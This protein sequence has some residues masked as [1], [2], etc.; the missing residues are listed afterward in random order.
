ML[1]LFFP[2]FLFVGSLVLAVS[3]QMWMSKEKL[4][5]CSPAEVI[6]HPEVLIGGWGSFLVS[7]LL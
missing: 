7:V 5:S 4:F 6:F 2:P 1:N 3:K